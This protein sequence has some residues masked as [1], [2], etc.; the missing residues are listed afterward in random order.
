M[1]YGLHQGH[2]GTVGSISPV[3]LRG[4]RIQNSTCRILQGVCIPT[5]T[6]ALDDL[7]DLM[8]ITEVRTSARLT[9]QPLWT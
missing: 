9:V 5:S 8:C 1:L 4:A 7:E 2:N 3:R 6:G